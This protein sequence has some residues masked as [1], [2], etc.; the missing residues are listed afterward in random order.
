MRQYTWECRQITSMHDA[1]LVG[2]PPSQTPRW[3]DPKS[4]LSIHP[5][6]RRVID[7]WNTYSLHPST[8]TV[9]VLW[10][11]SIPVQLEAMN[12]CWRS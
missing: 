10:N 11:T 7:M 4:S 5:R 1:H 6:A 3:G 12:T 2:L 9:G 8:L